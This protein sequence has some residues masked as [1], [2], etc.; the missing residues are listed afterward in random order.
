MSYSDAL[1][2]RLPLAKNGTA[3]LA[4]KVKTFNVNG[5]KIRAFTETGTMHP[6]I[7]GIGIPVNNASGKPAMVG[8]FG[9][10]QTALAYLHSQLPADLYREA[11]TATCLRWAQDPMTTVPHATF[12]MISLDAGLS[13]D[14]NQYTGAIAGVYHA[15]N[16]PARKSK[17]KKELGASA[18]EKKAAKPKPKKLVLNAGVHVIR[19]SL[20]EDKSIVEIT[21]TAEELKI[22]RKLKKRGAKAFTDE[23][24][25]E[26][27]AVSYDAEAGKGKQ[28]PWFTGA[29]GEFIVTAFKKVKFTAA[30]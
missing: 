3:K 24:G 18:I 1:L 29:S 11:H 26:F 23:Q 13:S 30:Q 19:P 27:Y 21:D 5:E 6:I 2:Q 14:I 15:A 10:V 16:V 12:E 28:N 25:N 8:L 7:Y 17:A 22:K 9:S 20:A 4:R